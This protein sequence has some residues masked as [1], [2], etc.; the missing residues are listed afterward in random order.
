MTF[1]V[2]RRLTLIGVYIYISANE[3]EEASRSS[4]FKSGLL[5]KDIFRGPEVSDRISA[6]IIKSDFVS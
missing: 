5:A 6:I 4:I 3:T 2:Q 1:I